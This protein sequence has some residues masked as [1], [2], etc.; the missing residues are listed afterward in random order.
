MPHKPLAKIR[1]Q[2]CLR[3]AKTF[4][5]N[6][7]GHLSLVIGEKRKTYKPSLIGR[8][9]QPLSGLPKAFHFFVSLC[10]PLWLKVDGG[11]RLVY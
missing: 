11:F 2:L 1:R 6:V 9:C 4:K 8:G 3:R 5:T 7:I 10:I